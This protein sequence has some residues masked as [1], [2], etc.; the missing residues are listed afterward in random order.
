[1]KCIRCEQDF[2]MPNAN[3][4]GSCADDLRQEEDAKL[5]EIEA[6]DITD[7]MNRE[8]YEEAMEDAQRDT[9]EGY[10]HI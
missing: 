5:G 1:M 2:E 4:C 9:A 6:A 7:Q 8:A 3:V 10:R